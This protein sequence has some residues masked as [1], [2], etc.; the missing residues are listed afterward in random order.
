MV[1][2]STFLSGGQVM[3]SDNREK[4]NLPTWQAGSEGQIW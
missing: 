2:R 1:R 4:D 3:R